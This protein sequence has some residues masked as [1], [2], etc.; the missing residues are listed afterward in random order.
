M[1]SI[2]VSGTLTFILLLCMSFAW[3]QG[4]STPPTFPEGQKNPSVN[5]GQTTRR[6]NPAQAN[7]ASQTDAPTM[8]PAKAQNQI[9]DA[10][11]KQLPASADSVVVGVLSDNR[12]QLSGT[13]SSERERQQIEQVARSAA[14]DQ[15]ILNSIAVSSPALP[16]SS[17]GKSEPPPPIAGQT[18]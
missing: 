14:P 17:G 15:V 4:A 5:P 16:P 13:V 2:R 7:P 18:Q 11:R 6:Q 9:Q 1:K 12:I 10:L 8:S 3:G